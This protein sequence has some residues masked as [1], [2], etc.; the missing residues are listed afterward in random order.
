MKKSIIIFS[1]LFLSSVVF[2]DEEP[3]VFNEMAVDGRVKIDCS[4]EESEWKKSLPLSSFSGAKDD[5]TRQQW[6][7]I[8]FQKCIMS[9]QK[10]GIADLQSKYNVLFN[11]FKVIYET[12]IDVNDRIE[13]DMNLFKGCSN[14]ETNSENVCGKQYEIFDCAKDVYEI[15]VKFEKDRKGGPWGFVMTAL[16]AEL[17]FHK[18][19]LDDCMINSAKSIINEYNEMK[20]NSGQIQKLS[21]ATPN[22]NSISDH[23]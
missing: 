1:S 20:S 15:Q 2:A 3:I 18:S 11:N 10:D 13:Y 8:T 16:N 5:I 23:I 19:R 12:S 4:K 6:S 21:P 22:N 14:I 9:A 17:L 7:Y